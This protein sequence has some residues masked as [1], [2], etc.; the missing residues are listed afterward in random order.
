[1]V[2]A[3]NGQFLGRAINTPLTPSRTTSSLTLSLLNFKKAQI[4]KISQSLHPNSL[5][6]G[7]LKEKAPIYYF[8]EAIY[9]SSPF[10]WGFRG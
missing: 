3:A 5:I 8:T 9:I 7:G 4:I 2:E 10:T 1:V 6:L